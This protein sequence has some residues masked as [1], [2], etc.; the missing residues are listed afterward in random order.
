MLNC[1]VNVL[2]INCEEQSHYWIILH[3]Q[4]ALVIIFQHIY[5]QHVYV[6]F[7]FL[8]FDH[9]MNIFLIWISFQEID[10]YLGLVFGP[11]IWTWFP[12]C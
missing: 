12:G 2:E 8:N 1:A 3:R 10:F 11:G 6:V 7:S 5:I 9:K 4:C